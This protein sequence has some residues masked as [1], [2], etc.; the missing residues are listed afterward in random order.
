[1]VSVKACLKLDMIILMSFT[2]RM[3]G[4]SR[5]ITVVQVEEQAWAIHHK[6]SPA[7]GGLHIRARFF[8]C[9]P[10]S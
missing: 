8:P 2:A 1:M 6:P 10:K 3:E 7:A 5:K 4:L 9:V